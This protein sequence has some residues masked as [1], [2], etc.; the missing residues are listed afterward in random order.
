MQT[1]RWRLIQKLFEEAV[2]LPDEAAQRNFLEGALPDDPGLVA[3]IVAML[4]EDRHGS[5]MLDHGAAQLAHSMLSASTPPPGMRIGRYTL[6]EVLG[7]GGMGV[8]CLAQREDLGGLVAIKF[9]RDAWLSAAR[10][11]RFA[12]EQR[13]LAQLNHPGIAQL[14]DADLLPDGTPWFAMEYV[15]GVP[16][17]AYCSG[18]CCT[19]ERRL[20]LLRQAC[21]AV[22]FAHAHA[23][24]HRD[25]KP[26]N[27]LVKEDG[28]VKLLDF[29]IAKQLDA[30][31]SPA[32]AT[33]TV[34]RLMTPAYAA[35]EQ[36]EGQKI[37]VHTD[38][39]ALGVVLYEL[40]TG[41]LPFDLRELS[42]P[43]AAAV[44]ASGYP[45]APSQIAPRTAHDDADWS[46]LD[47]LCLTAMHADP[48]R[49]YSSVEALI[50]DIDHYLAS[51]PLEARP[52]GWTYRCGKFLRRHW[53][54]S[55]VV[56]AAVLLVV[57]I[58]AVFALRLATAR[59]AALAEAARTQRVQ[60]LMTML[61]EGGE[62]LA[63]P[64]TSTRIVDV[65]DRGARE[66]QTL[67]ADPAVQADLLYA[68]AG[69]Y[70]KLRRLDQADALLQLSLQKRRHLFGEDSAQVAQCLVAIGLLRLDQARLAEGERLVRQGLEMT[71]RTLPDGHPQLIAGK[72]ALGK[73]LR[74]RGAHAEAIAVLTQAALAQ[75]APGVPPLDQASALSELADAFYSAGQ[76][77]RSEVQYRR[78]LALHQQQLGE[79]HPLVAS[80]LASLAAIQQD[81]GYYDAA[82]RLS[83]Q[84]LAITEGYYGPDS[85]HAADVLTSLGRALTYQRKFPEAVG[86]LQ[87]ALAIQEK[88]H[89]PAH[90]V[91][92]EAVN[93]LG[94]VMALQQRYAE[95]ERNFRRAAA[96]YRDVYGDRHY[97]VA[98]GMANVA[99]M[100][101]QQAQ[102]A[103]AE[104]LFR[105][106]IDVFTRTLS[107]DNV[108]TGI[109]RVKLGRTLL[110]SGRYAEAEQESLA[111]LAILA[112]Q[113]NSSISFVQAARKDL[114][115]IYEALQ[116]PEM[117]AQYRAE[118]YAL[119]RL[120][121]S[122][123]D[124]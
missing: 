104:A 40:L 75:S 103:S 16:L 83:R 56:S 36:L 93:E 85:G 32:L 91:V 65:L 28:S 106:V 45:P 101:M 4:H 117:A 54:I 113:A 12:A 109:A 114:V 9:L 3:Q 24:I 21:E 20:Q 23:V 48:A 13:L 107:A 44:A 97:L 62:E 5:S 41:R 121:S 82:E 87:R 80:D 57:A 108:N 78:V 33:R 120:P 30:L 31:E 61:F 27:I 98:I 8:V 66:A 7:E 110:R 17:T 123:A 51:E 34:L 81:L 49:R 124:H 18:H 102:Y 71:R 94:N 100:Q 79:R 52:D 84:S 111:G 29:G 116:R 122:E 68:I 43:E 47:V 90:P 42:A 2:E 86:T 19:V 69:I 64:G 112:G 10:R 50:R 46:D 14:H 6:R 22:R 76:Y 37:G 70:Q 11:E 26:S 105:E 99:Y 15:Q 118:R 25:I 77:A 119:A 53:Q 55:A 59:D 38:V 63:G 95:A 73:V 67:T 89:G 58:S 96:I 60:N 35:P 72:L 92:A 115:A 74:E 39:Y 1:S 88:V